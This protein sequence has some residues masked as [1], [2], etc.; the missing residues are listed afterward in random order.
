M[1]GHGL[2]WM[3]AGSKPSSIGAVVR[4]IAKERVTSAT[5]TPVRLSRTRSD[6]QGRVRGVVR[7]YITIESIPGAEMVTMNVPPNGIVCCAVSA[8]VIADN[9]SDATCP[10]GCFPAATGLLRNQR[11]MRGSTEASCA[12]TDSAHSARYIVKSSDADM[13]GVLSTNCITRCPLGPV[14]R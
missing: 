9:M 11:L 4:S 10:A 5:G 8:S 1:G 13:V 3:D 12:V 2:I 7:A 14:D 6:I